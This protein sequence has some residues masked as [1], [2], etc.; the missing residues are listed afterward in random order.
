[1][2]FQAS[3]S[4]EGPFGILLLKAWKSQLAITMCSQWIVTLESALY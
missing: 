4:S 3:V 1:M 2:P